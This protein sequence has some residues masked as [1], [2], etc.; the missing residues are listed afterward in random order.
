MVLLVLP[1]YQKLVFAHR[2]FE[3][4]R[5]ARQLFVRS[6]IVSAE[7]AATEPGGTAFVNLWQENSPCYS[8]TKSS[9]GRM[10]DRAK[11]PELLFI[12]V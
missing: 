8:T 4:T 2:Q 11:P 10:L 7:Q 5:E 12:T 9:E 3:K 1:Q 6:K